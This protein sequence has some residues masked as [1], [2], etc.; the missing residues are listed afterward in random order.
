MDPQEHIL[1]ISAGD[2]IHTTYPAM[3]KDLMTVTHTFIVAEK[4]VYTASARDDTQ[5]RMWKCAIRN[6]IEEVNAISISQ[7]IAC[8]LVCIDATAFD[9][10]RDPV[11]GIFS[12]HPPGTRSISPQAPNVSRWDSSLCHSGWRVLPVTHSGIPR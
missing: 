1:I 3:L 5:K 7:N 12:E 11:L 10:I 6:A 9:A 2:R 8:A 4:E